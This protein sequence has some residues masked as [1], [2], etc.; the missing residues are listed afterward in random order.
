MKLVDND[1]RHGVKLYS[2]KSQLTKLPCC[3]G[4]THTCPSLH[5]LRLRSSWTFKCE[6]CTS[7]FTG[8][9][10]G[11]NTRTSQPRR[12]RMRE[13]SKANRREYELTILATHTTTGRIT[14]MLVS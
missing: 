1:H 10:V 3:S 11:S 2:S 14:R 13:A 8:N 9:P 4:V 12:K 6:C 7:S 5:L